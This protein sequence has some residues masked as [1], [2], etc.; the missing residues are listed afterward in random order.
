MRYWCYYIARFLLWLFF[1]A[2]FDLKVSG[3]GY[4][5]KQGPFIVA[6][7]HVSYLDPPLIGVA[8]SRRCRFMARSSLFR[9]ALLG[10]FLRAVNVIP[11]E[12]GEADIGAIRKAINYL[13]KGEAIAIFP[14]GGRQL[15]G[16]VREVRRGVGLL[17]LKAKVPII[18]AFVRG[19]FEALPP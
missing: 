18:P 5:P 10:A 13:L 12:R 14:E 7:N 11:L 17:A 4:I 9:H 15:S 16:R 6:S 19:T 8:C 2:G 3:Q 1:R